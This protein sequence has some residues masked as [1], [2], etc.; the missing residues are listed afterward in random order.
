ME[1]KIGD[2]I[3]QEEYIYIV[4]KYQEYIC[5]IKTDYFKIGPFEWRG[6]AHPKDIKENVIISHSDY[7]IDDS[8]ASPFKNV[9]CVNNV[10]TLENTHSL[11]MGLP[12]DTD[13]MD[14][15]EIIGNKEV[16]MSV[17]NSNIQ[18]ENLLYI[19]FSTSTYPSLRGNLCKMFHEVSWVKREEPEY[20]HEGRKRYLEGI[21]KSKFVLCPRGNGIDT[22]R[23]WES[24]YLGSI[25]I[26]ERHRTHDMC[27]DLPVLFID[28]WRHINEEYLNEKYHEINE[29]SHN[30]DKLK[31]SYWENLIK[32]KIFAQTD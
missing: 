28:D 31:I 20:T 10:T 29:R 24:L 9:F 3:T 14:I 22:H 30:M 12:N 13:E 21:K 18:K 4:N 32:N 25:P 19:N 1:I 8:I 27:D 15:L 6:F 16:F 11:P 26:I 23:L 7:E 2:L 5:H 17:V